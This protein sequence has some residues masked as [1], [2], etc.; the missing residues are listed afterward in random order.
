MTDVKLAL[1]GLRGESFPD[2][3]RRLGFLNGVAISPTATDQEVMDSATLT[4]VTYQGTASGSADDLV[5]A[6]RWLTAGDLTDLPAGASSG[7]LTVQPHGDWVLQ[8]FHTLTTP[9]N[10]WWRYVRI[11]TGAVGPWEPYDRAPDRYVGVIASGA[12]S[13]NRS[14]GR[15]LVVGG[16]DTPP[17]APTGFLDVRTYGDTFLI[18]SFAEFNEPSRRFERRVTQDGSFIGDWAPL[19]R[20]LWSQRN[21]LWFGDSIGVGS[22]GS[23]AIPPRVAAA[24]QVK[25]LT[26][27][28]IGGT[29]LGTHADA[30]YNK[31]GAVS[32]FTAMADDDWT[33]VDAAVLVIEPSG[34][35]VTNLIVTLKAL[36]ASGL[37]ETTDIVVDLGRNDMN[38]QLPVGTNADAT[39]ATYLGAANL[40]VALVRAYDATIRIHFLGPIW[41]YRVKDETPG[42]LDTATTAGSGGIYL[43]QY[44]DALETWAPAAL[45]G[46]AWNGFRDCGIGPWNWEEL[47]GEL[48]GVHPTIPAGEAFVAAKKTA[49]LLTR[50]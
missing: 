8:Q 40:F 19:S 1:R 37:D 29:S 39:M 31:L 11:S 47:L 46:K 21:V 15:Y 45:R 25:R 13:D 5:I 49:W 33:D 9:G 17:G 3:A 28:S 42:T 32:L 14:N 10:A 18:Q 24:L 23:Q 20:A 41:S 48:D 27:A 7:Y 12:M 44:A 2:V 50:G 34:G 22:G 38:H 16:T 4:T 35:T 30:N 36:A 43:Y 26:N 6:G